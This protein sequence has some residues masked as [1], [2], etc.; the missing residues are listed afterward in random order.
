MITQLLSHQE[1]LQAVDLVMSE[2]LLEVE[3]TSPDGKKTR[4]YVPSVLL[5][6]CLLV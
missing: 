4:L 1:L 6:C 3:T 2:R 5:T